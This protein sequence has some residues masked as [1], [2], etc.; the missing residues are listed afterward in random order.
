[1]RNR[2]VLRRSD[3]PDHDGVRPTLAVVTHV[4]GDLGPH[5]GRH[6]GRVGR[7]E[8]RWE[9]KDRAQQ[10]DFPHVLPACL[11]RLKISS[12][13]VILFAWRAGVK[14]HPPWA[15]QIVFGNEGA[16][17]AWLAPEAPLTG[18]R[19]RCPVPPGTARASLLMQN[20]APS[21]PPTVAGAG[22]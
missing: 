8:G 14:A 2:A 6:G 9:D 17:G 10:Q 21:R 4:R 7:R 13:A 12:A 19:L 22:E 16:H 1:G 5:A 20:L 3:H 15:G 18:A 11:Y